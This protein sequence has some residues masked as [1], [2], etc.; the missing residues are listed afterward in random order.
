[1]RTYLSIVTCLALTAVPVFGVLIDR[2]A[3]T[4]G[5]KVIT[6]REITRRIRLAAFQNGESP[7][8]SLASRREAAQR[9]IDLKL[10]EREMDVGHYTR[11]PAAKA[12]ALLSAFTKNI[13]AIAPKRC[14]CHWQT[15]ISRQRIWRPSLPNKP[16]CCCLRAC[17]SALPSK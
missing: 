13:F 8:V 3:I 11:T 12:D 15:S 6:D 14:G 4:V 2:T 16:I 10:V 1:M 5:N 9:L 7:N 17:A